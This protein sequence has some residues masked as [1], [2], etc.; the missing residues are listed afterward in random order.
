MNKRTFIIIDLNQL[1][2]EKAYSFPPIGRKD[3]KSIPKPA[4][5][6]KDFKRKVH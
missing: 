4:R 2:R 1:D 6:G 5:T 3:F